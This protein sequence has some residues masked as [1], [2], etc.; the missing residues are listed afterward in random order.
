MVDWNSDDYWWRRF[1]AI[2]RFVNYSTERHP[3]K[4]NAFVQFTHKQIDEL[5]S[6]YGKID[7]LWMDGGWARAYDS[8]ELVKERDANYAARKM[9]GNPQNEDMQLSAMAKNA[10]AKQPGVLL[11]ARGVAGPY[12][13]YLTPEQKIPESGLPYPWE[14]CM[15]MG[16]HWAYVASDTYKPTEQLIKVLVDIVSK[17]GNLL[18]NVGPKPDGTL[19]DTVYQRLK[20]IGD[21][22]QINSEAIYSTR[23]NDFYSDGE[24][25]RY[26][27]SKD[28]KTVYVFLF[29]FPDTAFE[30]THLP[31]K[32]PSKIKM[33]GAKNSKGIQLKNTDK[34]IRVTLNKNLKAV[35]NY[36]W[37]LKFEE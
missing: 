4:W 33:L 9:Y 2:D 36:V 31:F 3:E 29:N 6:N 8:A 25:I 30:L 14:T 34:G 1:P 32:N 21:W 15:T 23:K 28:G 26:T 13:N 16:V 5:M 11:V 18:L 17:G 20:E 19:P 37:V 7:I 24:N 35:S 10:R 27:K 22:M 12:Q